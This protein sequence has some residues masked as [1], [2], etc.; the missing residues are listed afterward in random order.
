MGF[1]VLL[2]AVLAIV[3]GIVVLNRYNVGLGIALI[4][5]G[6]LVLVYAFVGTGLVRGV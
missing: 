3:G 6:A 2:L 5:V 1:L 4:V